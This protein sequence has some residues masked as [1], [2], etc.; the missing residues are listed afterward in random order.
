VTGDI[1]HQSITEAATKAPD[2]E[3]RGA[4][5]PTKTTPHA[6]DQIYEIVEESS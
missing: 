2:R 5:K 6:M 3:R 4:S 1:S